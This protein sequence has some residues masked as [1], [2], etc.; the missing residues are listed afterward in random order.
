M[1]NLLDSFSIL[2]DILTLKNNDLPQ[3]IKKNVNRDDTDIYDSNQI[4]KIFS[5]VQDMSA[6]RFESSR[7]PR[8]TGIINPNIR[9]KASNRK[10]VEHFGNVNNKEDKVVEHFGNVKKYNPK[11]DANNDSEFSDDSSIY[12]NDSKDSK[13][14]NASSVSVMG[15]PSL[16]LT[17]S[18]E[19]VDNRKR[20]RDI[21]DKRLGSKQKEY[22]SQFET[23]KFD[24]KGGPVSMNAVPDTNNNNRIHFERDLAL[25]GSYSNFGEGYGNSN[26]MSYGVNGGDFTHTNMVPQFKSKSY[27]SQP[28]RDEK[29]R[30]VGQRKMEL[31]SGSVSIKPPKTERAPLFEPVV[32]ATNIYGMPV[33]ADYTSDRYIPGAEKRSEK[34]FQEKRITPGLNLGYNESNAMGDYYRPSYKTIDELRTADKAQTSYTMP[35]VTSGIRGERGPVVGE[36]MKY[37]PERTKE[38]GTDRMV[39]NYGYAIAPS[40]Y[41]EVNPKNMA[42]TNRGTTQ[43]MY[44]GPAQNEISQVTSTELREKFNGSLKQ[45]FKEAEPRNLFIV[46]GQTARE[47]EEKFIPDPTQRSQNLNYVGPAGSSSIG[48]TQAYDPNDVP[49]STL[50]DIHNKY[51]RFG[52]AITGNIY[53]GQYYDPNDVMDPTLRDIH[54]MYD[55]EGK[56]ITGNIF[57]GHTYDPNDVPDPTLRDIHN[58]YD[59]EGKAITGNIFKGHTY[60]PNDVPDPT[61][62][63]IHN[64]YDRDGKAITGNYF[65]GQAYDPNDVPD[66]TKREMHSKLD[67][68]AGGATFEREKGYTVNY[69]LM[70]PDVTKREIHSKLDRSA[71]GATFE[72]EKGYT[73]NYDLMTP[74]VTKREMHSKLDR[75]AGGATFER[76]KGYAVNYDLMTSDVTKREMHSKLDRSAGGATFE[77]EKG[78]AINYDLITPDVTKRE[79]H[80][81]LDRSAGGATFEREKGYTINYDLMTPDVTK[82]EMHSKLDRSAGGA[83]FEREKGYTINYDLMTPDVTKREMHSKLDRT[84]GGAGANN[85]FLPRTREDYENAIINV[86]KE[87]IEIINRPPTYSNYEKGPTADFTMLRVCDKIQINRA[88]LPATIQTSDK[89]PFSMQSSSNLRTVENT[90]I[91]S[92]VKINLEGNPYINNVIHK[93]V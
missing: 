6:K 81:K 24:T 27:G 67:R 85:I 48:K 75:S 35:V 21:V 2:K 31:F 90:R 92:H 51:D 89:L 47:D 5:K 29:L 30:E 10:V 17:R 62:R 60:D 58:M 55:R 65:K 32:N 46:E 64:M 50:R 43:T 87:Q 16:L 80:S 72:R 79:M 20:E 61:L 45:S 70:T 13:D 7:N 57:K 78:Y 49:N 53:K 71:G 39:K 73:V 11:K 8:K 1:N 28:H 38:W 23:Q 69:D 26:D 37:R 66:V 12:S 52:N 86:G 77:R 3:N 84:G 18:S 42:T 63:N 68:S 40:V 82:R 41:G 36:Q 33:M 74:D 15:D 44:I 19:M 93:S 59:R 9:R 4:K 25:S 88:A 91:D 54:N 56:A 14:S 34:P 76:E 83:T 22:L